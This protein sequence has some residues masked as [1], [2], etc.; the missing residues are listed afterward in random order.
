MV[1]DAELGILLRLV[2]HRDSTPVSRYELRDVVVG[3]DIRI[4][5]PEGVGPGDPDDGGSG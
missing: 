2:C 4:D 5:I 3:G 1:A